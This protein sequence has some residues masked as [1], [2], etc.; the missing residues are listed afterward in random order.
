M[1]KF[2]KI[3]VVLLAIVVVLALL[4]NMIIQGVLASQIS[5]AAHVPVSIGSTDARLLVSSIRLKDIQVKNPKGFKEKLMIDI[6]QIYIDFD[7]KA[8]T[9]G[10]AHFEEVRLDL[11]EVVVVK[12]SAGVMNIDAVKPTPEEK[13]K[14]KEDAARKQGSPKDKK[15]ES[16]KLQIDKL[17]LTIGR[18]IYKDYSAGGEPNIQEFNVN[19]RERLYTNIKNPSAVVSLIMFEVL[20]NTALS[21]LAN[22]DISIFK[23]GAAGALAGS[24]GLVGDG[25]DTFEDTAKGL[26]KLFD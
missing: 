9:K 7:P 4:K 21:R 11:K 2:V 23:D 8:I 12:N 16:P 25:V 17:Y 22:L 19:I 20:T 18:V 1:K 6:P 3:L 26:I 10:V 5:K 13:A 14:Q 24:L 15:G